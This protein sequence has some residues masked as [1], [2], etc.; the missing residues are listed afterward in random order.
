MILAR[1]LLAGLMLALAVP[2]AS[3]PLKHVIVDGEPLAYI[4]QGR[5]DPLVLVHGGLQDYRLWTRIIRK[6]SA[7]YRVIAYSRRN[8]FPNRVSREGWPD[9]AADLHAHDLAGV[10][11]ALHL[12]PV[13]L[14]AHS[15]GAHAALFFASEHPELLRS[16]VVNEPPASGLLLQSYEDQTVA[17]QFGASLAPAREAFRRGDL[18]SGVRLF[19]DAV[20]G[21]GVYESR[22]RS[23]RAMLMDNAVAHQAD[24]LSQRPRPVYTCAMA[25]KITAPV[26]ITNGNRS[27]AFF[28]RIADELARCVPHARRASFDASHGVP[29][30]SPD[31]FGDA[32]LAFL[33]SRAR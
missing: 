25:R 19:T 10:I 6:L 3:Y 11:R 8:H 27:P 2:A 13:N 30:E 33:Q 16:L 15:S 14:V 20:S 12:G 32:V 23:E 22:S 5:G 26:L 1:F 9:P 24:A 28:H 18:R 7:H 17:R 31:S 29:L 4:D 21:P